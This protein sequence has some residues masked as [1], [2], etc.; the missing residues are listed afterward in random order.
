MGFIVGAHHV[1]SLDSSAVPI[2][3]LLAVRQ[4][5]PSRLR[6]ELSAQ[7]IPAEPIQQWRAN[8]APNL[9]AQADALLVA[10]DQ[11]RINRL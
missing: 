10:V 4:P 2:P 3:G 5:R 9:P 7:P 11:V 6:C 1:R 8:R